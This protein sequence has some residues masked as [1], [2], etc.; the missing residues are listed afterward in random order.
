MIETHPFYPFIPSKTKFLLLGSFP[1]RLT[2]RF[3]DWYYETKK[4]QFWTILRSVYNLKLDSKTEK[5][6]LFNKLHIAITDIIY[7]CERK[8]GNN[9]D[10][11]L[12]NIS[13][14]TDTISNILKSNRIRKI[15]FSSRFVERKFVRVFKNFSERY[16]DIELIILPSSSPRYAKLS[17]QD[18]IKIYKK[19][20]PEL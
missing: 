11:N 13:Y 6:L 19:L 14:N 10:A 9:S 17:L 20:L 15:Y 2:S 1:G 3:G 5:Q 18:K 12:I 16:K 7:M 4:G 8:S